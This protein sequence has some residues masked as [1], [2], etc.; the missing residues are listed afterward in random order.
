MTEIAE[1]VGAA[2]AYGR[3]FTRLGRGVVSRDRMMTPPT[4][5][6]SGVFLVES[7]YSIIKSFSTVV[8]SQR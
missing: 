3:T 4:G 6:Y 2:V 5:A 8:V 1:G 7:V